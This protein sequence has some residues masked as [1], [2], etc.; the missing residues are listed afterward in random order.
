MYGK[1]V[2]LIVP[3]EAFVVK[4]VEPSTGTRAFINMCTSSKVGGRAYKSIALPPPPYV[5]TLHRQCNR[6]LA[7]ALF[8]CPGDG[9]P[10]H[11]EQWRG[12]WMWAARGLRLTPDGALAFKR[13]ARCACRF[14]S[15]YLQFASIF[16]RG[17]H[18]HGVHTSLDHDKN[19]LR[20]WSPSA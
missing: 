20:R 10:A 19:T 14:A 12:R 3:E 17:P 1:D 9:V 11:D 15:P 18:L 4:T 8:G 2:T 13:R 6:P 7:E 5:R 16:M